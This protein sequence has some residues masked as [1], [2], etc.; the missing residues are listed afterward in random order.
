MTTD[1]VT[2]PVDADLSAVED[3]FRRSRHRSYPVVDGQEQFVGMVSRDDLLGEEEITA[4]VSEVA[5][6]DVATVGASESL[7]VALR[8]MV[9][10]GAD[11]LPVVEQGRLVGI[12][13]RTDILRARTRELEH[14]RPEH[15][16]LSLRSRTRTSAQIASAGP[17]ARAEAPLPV[18]PAPTSNGDGAAVTPS[19]PGDPV[20]QLD[21]P[22][23]G[24]SS[25]S[26][27]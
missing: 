10:E 19:D 26:G 21:P 4:S 8:R 20:P 11:N 15:G 25:R 23:T 17:E 12:C 22:P 24:S 1:V 6:R 3:A 9:E 18:A 14:E 7:Q 16:W 2:V 13:T 5:N 27:R